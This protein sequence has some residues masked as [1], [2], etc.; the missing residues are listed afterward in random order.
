M[1]LYHWLLLGFLF[2]CQSK[3]T[4]KIVKLPAASK[5]NTIFSYRKLLHIPSEEQ[6]GSRYYEYFLK[7]K[8]LLQLSDSLAFTNDYEIRLYI[9]GSFGPANVF[10]MYF[11]MSNGKARKL[12]KPIF[13]KPRQQDILFILTSD[14]KFLLKMR[15]KTDC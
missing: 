9:F 11:I 4:E 3:K 5:E 15:S 13:R 7:G 8:K 12:I 2:S 6:E 10:D 14:G 1:K